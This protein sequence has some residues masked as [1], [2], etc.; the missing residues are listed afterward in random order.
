MGV[1]DSLV[2]VRNLRK[3]YD[4]A[5]A[6]DGVSFEVM[7]GEIFGLL[8]PNGAGKTTILNMLAGIVAPTEGEIRI[9]GQ[10]IRRAGVA[11]KRAMGVVPQELAIYPDRKSTRLN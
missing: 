1:S 4:T 6:V 2:L 5:T 10:D 11:V 7:R 8:G 3:C 9:A